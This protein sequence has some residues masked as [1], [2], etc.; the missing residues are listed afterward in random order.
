MPLRWKVLIVLLLLA[1]IGLGVCW[2]VNRN[3]LERHWMIYQ[4]GAAPTYQ[5]AKSKLTWFDAPA[6]RSA[7]LP[8]LLGRFGRGNGR[9]DLYLAQYV[10][11]RDSSEA[12]REAFSHQ[13]TSGNG[14]LARWANYWSWRLAQP[15]DAEI[16]SILAY[17]DVLKA[18]PSKTF[19]WREVLDLQAVFQWTGR[20]ELAQKLS[21]GNWRER[22]RQWCVD[23]PARLP[24]VER[25]GEPMPGT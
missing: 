17:L 20:P 11:D 8:V 22:Y 24:H 23:R 10:D 6:E 21:P 4:V 19:T 14:L 25:P 18:A 12:L 2:Y 3:F 16:A 15:P 1:G 13:L 7:R 9:F 5:E